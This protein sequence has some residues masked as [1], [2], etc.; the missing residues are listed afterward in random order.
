M[1]HEEREYYTGVQETKSKLTGG[2]EVRRA[3]GGT[4]PFLAARGALGF[5]EV[6]CGSGNVNSWPALA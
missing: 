2:K 5:G 3:G 4:V 6:P 1:T